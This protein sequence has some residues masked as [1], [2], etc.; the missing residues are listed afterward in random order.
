[1]TIRNHPSGDEKQ[2]HHRTAPCLL[3][4]GRPVHL[5]ELVRDRPIKIINPDAVQTACAFE[6]I[7]Q[8]ASGECSSLRELILSSEAASPS[9]EIS[10][11]RGMDL[12]S[13]L[14]NLTQRMSPIVTARGDDRGSLFLVQTRQMSGMIYQLSQSISSIPC[15]NSST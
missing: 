12:A 2:L 9:W 14:G 3:I 8:S 5:V 13:F 10:F 7:K 4:G 1:M 15:R 11:G 6:M